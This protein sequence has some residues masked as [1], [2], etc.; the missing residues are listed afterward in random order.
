[1]ETGNTLRT[2]TILSP[3]FWN[4]GGSVPFQTSGSTGAAKQI[5]LTKEALL[6][7]ARAVNDWL[8]VDATSVWG[9]ALPLNH[10]GGFGVAA[11]A[12]A[13]GCG[14]AVYGGKW[15][16]ARFAEWIAEH[17][18]THVSLVPTQIHDLLA[19]ALQAPPSLAAVVVGGGKLSEESGQAARN[20]GWPVLASY[21]M[22]EAASQIATQSIDS[23]EL[24]FAASPL[25]LLPIWEAEETPEGLLRIKGEA[26]FAGT[27]ENG[28][29]LRREGDWFA[30]QDRV[31]VAG[32]IL[33]PQGRADSRVKVMGELIDVEAVEKRFLDIA[34]G[35]VR[36]GTFAIIPIPDPRRENALLAVFEGNS[37]EEIIA[38]YQA[39]APG[40]ERFTRW[41]ALEA[42][43][44]TDLGKLRRAELRLICTEPKSG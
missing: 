37:P 17:R 26:L 29:F 20:K 43:P 30:T 6:L 34:Q 36:E 24:P 5:V 12:Y 40:P 23:L 33:I 10:V 19:A 39:Q 32:R 11:R 8:R 44:R 27:I 14:L 28:T 21:G 31:R 22:T 16:A 41:I 7:S 9:L 13:A 1:L 18:V 15:D 42:F 25:E 3:G 38:A 35:A 2:E 4:D